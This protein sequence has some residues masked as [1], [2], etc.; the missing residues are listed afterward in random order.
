MPVFRKGRLIPDEKYLI[1]PSDID[2]SK[3]FFGA[4][5]YNGAARI[6]RV[7]VRYCQLRDAWSTFSPRDLLTLG[8]VTEAEVA[9][10]MRLLQGYI[11]DQPGNGQSSV[12][13]DFVCRIWQLFPKE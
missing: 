2:V 1:R 3:D 13:H 5:D 10:K 11:V 9:E 7:I 4:F 6:A 12:T 8:D